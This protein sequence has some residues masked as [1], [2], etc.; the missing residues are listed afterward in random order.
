[1]WMVDGA[2][3]RVNGDADVTGPVAAAIEQLLLAALDDTESADEDYRSGDHCLAKPRL[4]D[5]A[6]DV[7]KRRWPDKYVFD[8]QGPV[9]ERDRQRNEILQRRR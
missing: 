9:D 7:L 6:G 4:C 3:S 1:M 8:L 2:R 5:V